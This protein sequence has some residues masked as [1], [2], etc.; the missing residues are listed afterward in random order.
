L[1][2]PALAPANNGNWQTL[3]RWAR[4]LDGHCRTR[5]GTGWNGEDCDLLVALHA[6][7]SAG[8]V[9]AFREAHPDRPLVLVLTGTDLYRD[10][11]HDPA[12]R[13]SLALAD[14]LVVLQPCGPMALP[15]A[16]RAR[17][18]VIFQSA[19]RL[20]PAPRAARRLR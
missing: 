18:H 14:H 6:R 12:A 15:P 10:I 8:A 16:L 1:V 13:R 11:D 20:K 19:R 3:S 17:C 5:I 4:M 9:Q 2:G 7:R